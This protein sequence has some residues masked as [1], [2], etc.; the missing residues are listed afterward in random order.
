MSGGRFDYAYIRVQNFADE[1]EAWLDQPPGSDCSPEVLARLRELVASSRRHAAMMRHAEWFASGD[2]GE[3]TF[4]ARA[5]A[6]DLRLPQA[7]QETT[8]EEQI[9]ALADRLAVARERER[10]VLTVGMIC[11][12]LALLSE[13][14]GPLESVTR[15]HL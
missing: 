2:A 5:A 15:T 1:L 3:E 7:M 10:R 4:L 11:A 9:R 14:I 13:L 12:W 8:A 6:I